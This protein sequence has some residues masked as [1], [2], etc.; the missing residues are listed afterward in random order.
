[1]D[2]DSKADT[3]AVITTLEVTRGSDKVN[4]K[5]YQWRTWPDRSVPQSVMAP[6][7][8]LKIARSSAQCTVVHCSAGW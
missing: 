8:L 1:M 7:R 2:I 4:V 3:A 6:F 5:H